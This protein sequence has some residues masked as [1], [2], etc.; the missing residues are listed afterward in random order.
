MGTGLAGAIFWALDTVILSMA[1]LQAAFGGNS[2]AIFLAPFVSTFL[3]D[4][5]SCVWMLLYMGKKREYGNVWNALRT[6]NG[7]I[8]LVG[9]L[10]GGPVGMTGYVFAI[11]YLGASYTAMLS[12]LYPA[13]GTFF[14]YVFLKEKMTGRQMGG[15][16]L[17]IAGMMILGALSQGDEPQNMMIGFLCAMLCVMGWSLEAVICA[18]AMKNTAITNEHALM[19]RQGTSALFHGI[20]IMNAVNGW[21]MAGRAARTSAFWIIAAAALAG[22]ASY[23]FYYKAIYRIG[24]PKAMALN[25]T[26]VF[27]AMLFEIVLLKKIPAVLSVICGLMILAG[28]IIAALETGGGKGN[29]EDGTS[30]HCK[31]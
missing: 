1:M 16:F 2:S 3:H 21:E 30:G 7:K 26:Y 4:F 31:E 13:L 9:S 14:A 6:K 27:W 12:A 23:L 20:V 10:L 15:L 19:I 22:T 11:K 25:V 8:L 24:S 18:Y 28:A 5:C 29:G 17:S